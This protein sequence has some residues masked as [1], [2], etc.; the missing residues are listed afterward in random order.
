M[1]WRGVV[2][3]V[4][5]ERCVQCSMEWSELE[6]SGRG[7]TGGEEWFSG[8]VEESSRGESSGVEWNEVCPVE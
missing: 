8:G 1:L 2:W 3:V 6:W 7:A 4:C 5:A